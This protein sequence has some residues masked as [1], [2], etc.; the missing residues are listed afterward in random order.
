MISKN[1]IHIDERQG[2]VKSTLACIDKI[3]IDLNW[4]LYNGKS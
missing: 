1:Q 4:R 3:E 2:E